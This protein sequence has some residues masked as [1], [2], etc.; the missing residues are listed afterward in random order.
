MGG[1]RRVFWSERQGG[2]CLLGRGVV[3]AVRDEAKNVSAVGL[4]EGW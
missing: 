4:D 2:G 1:E 3:G